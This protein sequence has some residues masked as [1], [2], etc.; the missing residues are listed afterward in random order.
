MRGYFLLEQRKGFYK[1][2]STFESDI[3]KNDSWKY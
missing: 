1:K 2:H 3:Q